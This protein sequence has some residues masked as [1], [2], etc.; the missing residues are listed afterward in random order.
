MTKFSQK[1]GR[2]L[3]P[4]LQTGSGQP[5]PFHSATFSTFLN[6]LTADQQAAKELSDPHVAVSVALSSDIAP[7]TFNLFQTVNPVSILVKHII[8]IIIHS[9]LCQIRHTHRGRAPYA[10]LHTLGILSHPAAQLTYR[11]VSYVQVLLN[12]VADN[13]YNILASRLTEYTYFL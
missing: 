5:A 11:D 13:S 3:I 2:P 4:A 12:Q 7:L 8:C 10:L 1:G 6:I 9:S